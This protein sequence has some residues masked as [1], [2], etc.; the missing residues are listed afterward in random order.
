MIRNYIGVAL[1]SIGVM[2]AGSDSILIPI[3]MIAIGAWLA[4]GLIYEQ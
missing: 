1:I 3:A 2:S 4:R